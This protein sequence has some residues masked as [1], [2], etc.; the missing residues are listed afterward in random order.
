MM[1]AQL[2]GILLPP[3][4]CLTASSSTRIMGRKSSPPLVVISQVLPGCHNLCHIYMCE[5]P[6]SRMNTGIEEVALLFSRIKQY[7]FE[8]VKDYPGAPL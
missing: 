3:S 1:V 7:I 6:Q 8:N 5:R 4:G 2:Q